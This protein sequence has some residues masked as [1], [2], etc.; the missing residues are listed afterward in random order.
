[1]PNIHEPQL[2][3]TVGHAAGAIIFGIFLFLLLHDRRGRLRESWRSIAAAALAFLWNVGS[4]GVIVSATG[5]SQSEYLIVFSFCALSVLP[6]VLLDLS[7]SRVFKPLVRLGYSLSGVAVLMHLASLFQGRDFRQSAL[8]LITFGFG[9]LTAIALVGL[10][11]RKTGDERGLTSR[12]FAAMCSAIFA[13]SF[14]HFGA[15]HAPHPWSQELALHHAGIPLALFVL[16]QDDRFILLDAFIRF[17]ANALLAAVLT[18]AAIRLSSGFIRVGGDISDRPL[19]EG[20][21]GIAACLLL[22]FFALLRA[23]VQKWLTRVVFRRPDVDKALEEL[24]G[25][26]V[27]IGTEGN[28][29]PWASER[30]A[31]FMNTREVE[32]IDEPV[33]RDFMG[34]VELVMPT[35]TADIPGFRVQG[36]AQWIQALVP[37]RFSPEDIRYIA[38]GRRSGGRRYLSEDLGALGRL[39]AAIVEQVDRFRASEMQRLVSQAELRALQSQINPHFLFN[40]LNTLYGLIPR[41]ASG[42]R[43]TVMNLSDVFRYFLQTEKTF[44]LLSEELQ[45]VKAYLEIEALRFGPR[46]ETEIE[47]DELAL[48]TQIPILSIQPLVENAVKHGVSAS[49]NAGRLRVRVKAMDDVVRITVEDT[50]PGFSTDAS[51]SP[52]GAGVGL[53]NVRKRLKLCYGPDADLSIQRGQFGT[54]VEFSVPRIRVAIASS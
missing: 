13:M 45:I 19:Y 5:G 30:L 33:V 50:G 44:I 32:I 14:V 42:A 37:L 3:N 40:A 28:Y 49:P 23:G 35:P 41:D 34:S 16:L 9:I 47:A 46:L 2:V 26:S 39:S 15:S 53:A 6:A 25:G 51:G 21:L 1:M 18:F 22:I 20:L 52:A 24:R 38:L 8:V 10:V 11:L 12:M 17:L 54:R 27:R 7:L 43:R 4:L 31:Q 29:L 48:T 36:H